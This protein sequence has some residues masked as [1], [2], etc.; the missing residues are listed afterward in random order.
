MKKLA[1]LFGALVLVTG[2]TVPSIA[3]TEYSVSQKT[4]SAFNGSTT[5]L[6]AQQKAQVK[7]AVDANPSAEKFICTGIR[8]ESAPMSENI[9]VRKRAKAACDYAKTLNPNLST[10]FQNKPTKARSYAGKVLLTIKTLAQTEVGKTGICLEIDEGSAAS[11]LCETSNADVAKTGHAKLQARAKAAS[12]EKEVKVN[13]YVSETLKTERARFL[14]EAQEAID[15]HGEDF[16]GDEIQVMLFAPSDAAWARTTWNEISKGSVGD[17][18]VLGTLFG[19]QSISK[20]YGGQTRYYFVFAFDD[21]AGSKGSGEFMTHEF[22]HLVQASHGKSFSYGYPEVPMPSWLLEGAATYTSAAT[23]TLAESNGI[24]SRGFRPELVK[25]I[26]A[27]DDQTVIDYFKALETTN[28][29]PDTAWKSYFFGGLASELIVSS[30]GY[31]KLAEFQQ[32]F[33]SSAS[34][35]ANFQKVFGFSIDVF[36]QRAAEYV[37]YVVQT[38]TRG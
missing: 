34:T 12:G 10:W 31:E 30:F 24:V 38:R 1:A 35:A 37:R 14:S 16:L 15:F 3:S 8:F 19:G 9:T 2:L 6:T 36:Y 27:G 28:N 21:V 18:Y 23:L 32:S 29:Q 11:A 26:R 5:T 22:T 4:L 17:I 13:L 33:G 7:A 20:Q 25:E